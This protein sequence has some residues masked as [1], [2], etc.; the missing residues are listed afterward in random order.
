MSATWPN[1]TAVVLDQFNELIAHETS[2]LKAFISLLLT[3]QQAL[4]GDKAENLAQALTPLA[5]QKTLLCRQL[6][7][8]GRQRQMFIARHGLPAARQDVANWVA[9]RPTLA[10]AWQ[11][12]M[13][14]AAL[15]RS[16]N[17]Q[18][19][20]LI[21]LRLQHNRAALNV[22]LAAADKV[23]VYGPDGHQPGTF[24]RGRLWGSG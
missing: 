14:D 4:A 24:G 18:N 13:D 2:A 15:A 19:G 9:S 16:L 8:Q 11:T 5:E 21:N 6:E 20:K 22:L 3:E 12:L 17:E 7:D 1:V 10:S 23:S